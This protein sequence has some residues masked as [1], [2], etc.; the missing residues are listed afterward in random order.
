MALSNTLSTPTTLKG[1]TIMFRH[2]PRIIG[3][4]CVLNAMQ[5][6]APPAL[7][8]V[9]SFDDITFWVGSGPQRAAFVVDWSA[10]PDLPPLAWGYRWSGAATG[11]QMFRAIAAADANFRGRISA[12]GPLGVEL[13]GIGYDRDGDGFQLNDG[14]QFTDGLAISGPSD[15]AFAL[16]PDDS[17]NEGWFSAGFWGYYFATGSPYL[18]GGMWDFA[19]VGFSSRIL[20]D[21]EWDGYAYAPQFVFATPA[22]PVAAVPEPGLCQVLVGV[23]LVWGFV[24]TLRSR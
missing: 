8:E 9:R 17:Y 13:Y 11:D 23:G 1:H 7:A 14:T 15:T 4:L 5:W 16:D 10:T 21:G 24:R 22:V 18:P 12:G 6:G 20:A 19:P 3:L 2:S